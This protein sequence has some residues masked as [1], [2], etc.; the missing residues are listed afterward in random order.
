MKFQFLKTFLP[1]PQALFI[2]KILTLLWPHLSP[3]IHK[4][5]MKQA[6]APIA[7]ALEKIALVEDI[8]I[9]QLDL[10]ERPFRVDSF[11]TYKAFGD[12]I[13]MET[14]IFWGGDLRVRVTAVL[15]LGSTCIDVPVDIANIQIKALARITIPLVD[16]L[17]CTG[18]VNIS[19]LEEPTV[20]CDL[21]IIDSPDIMALPGIP[22]AIKSAISIVAG[23]MLVYPNEFS[24]PLMENYGRP[25]PPHGMLKVTVK[26]GHGLKSSLMDTVDPFVS[27]EIREG[28]PARTTTIDNNRD[29]VWDEDLDLVVDDPAKQLL[30][31]V[32]FDD[33]LI[34]ADTVGGA[35]VELAY[36][37]FVQNPGQPVIIRLPIYAPGDEGVFPVA[38][39]SDLMQF[40]AVAQNDIAVASAVAALPMKRG[41]IGK[42]RRKK[43]AKALATSMS[44]S[45]SAGGGGGSGGIPPASPL[46]GGPPSTPR[47]DATGEF[48]DQPHRKQA[49]PGTVTG[50]ITLEVTYMPF[51]G[52]PPPPKPPT[53]EEIAAAAEAEAIAATEA[54]AD[55]ATT[56]PAIEAAEAVAD[57]V[58]DVK[59]GPLP[60]MRRTLHEHSFAAPSPDQ[61]GVLTVSLKKVM[62]L[63]QPTDSYVTLRLYDPHRLPVPDIITKTKVEMNEA[64]PRFNFITDFVNISASSVL[65]LT[66]FNQPGAMSALTSLRVPLLQKAAPKP[67]GKVR[68]PLDQVVREGRV[69]TIFPLQ[70]AQ[71]G[72][73]HLTLEWSGVDLGDATEAAAAAV[74]KADTVVLEDATLAAVNAV[75]PAAAPVS[76][77][78]PMTTA[79]EA[80]STAT[81]VGIVDPAVNAVAAAAGTLPTTPTTT[82][83]L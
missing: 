74:T 18:G 45:L 13:I 40:V 75:K 78:V 52:A 65:T 47:S 7:E 21:N 10:G 15:K 69:N 24:L 17:P 2:N 38:Q 37:D 55:A 82:V 32:V 5:V 73:M 59:L 3:A 20:D 80:N 12:E 6:K 33:D 42:L 63:A 19:L 54:A 72:E 31:V 46:A 1:N 8:R 4:E 70:E 50:S 64:S 56:T 79:S 77:V 35:M 76:V 16:T 57:A 68:V 49:P 67:L 60:S 44:A 41:L 22:L 83:P 28:R 27:C 43:E 34:S 62:H 30:K 25:L 39:A 51:K 48:D 71:T 23:K 81:A 53:A 58:A 14:P 29:P 66:I 9:D 26:S 36:A 11:K 61:K